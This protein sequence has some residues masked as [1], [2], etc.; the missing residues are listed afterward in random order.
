MVSMFSRIQ[1]S[2]SKKPPLVKYQFS[3]R[4]KAT[5]NSGSANLSGLP[6]GPWTLTVSPSQVDQATA[7]RLRSSTSSPSRRLL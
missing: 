1:C 7:Q 3:I 5:A 2:L 4:A 6:E